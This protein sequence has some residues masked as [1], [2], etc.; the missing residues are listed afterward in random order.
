MYFQLEVDYYSNEANKNKYTNF[1]LK[2]SIKNNLKIAEDQIV[3]G[4][5]LATTT[6]H[7]LLFGLQSTLLLGLIV[8]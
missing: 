8:T 1:Q 4:I 7:A 3:Q 6:W 2:A 5:V